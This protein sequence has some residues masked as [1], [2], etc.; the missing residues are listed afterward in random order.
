[1]LQGLVLT[2]T[3]MGTKAVEVPADPTK[4]PSREVVLPP[5]GASAWSLALA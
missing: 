2:E 1:M 4:V 5:C 3:D